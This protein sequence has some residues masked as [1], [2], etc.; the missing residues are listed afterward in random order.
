MGKGR[1][2]VDSDVASEHVEHEVEEVIEAP[3]LE[4]R[5]VT[6]QW[7]RTTRMDHNFA[8]SVFQEEQSIKKCVKIQN[9]EFD[10]DHDY[11]FY[12]TKHLD[13]IGLNEEPVKL[14]IRTK[15]DFAKPNRLNNPF[16]PAP[17]SLT[18][19]EAYYSKVPRS[20]T[21]GLFMNDPQRLQVVKHPGD[22]QV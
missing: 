17:K 14:N 3:V 22:L 19:Y 9:E 10:Q 21:N 8:N 13:P 15:P 1:Q 11:P 7:S 18:N 12:G 4:P 16:A 5:S 2:A 6:K 20:R